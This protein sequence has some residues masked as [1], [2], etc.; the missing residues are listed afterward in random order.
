MPYLAT[1]PYWR[2]ILLRAYLANPNPCP[3]SDDEG[4]ELATFWIE[5]WEKNH[6]VHASN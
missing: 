4:G 3:I 6:G 2:V 1:S 5:L